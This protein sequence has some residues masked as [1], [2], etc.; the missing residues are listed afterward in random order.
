MIALTDDLN[1]DQA[2]ELGG[3]DIELH[4]RAVAKIIA[5]GAIRAAAR[6]DPD[7]ESKTETDACEV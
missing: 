7:E 5:M 2:I 4:I 1:Y 3:F 6:M